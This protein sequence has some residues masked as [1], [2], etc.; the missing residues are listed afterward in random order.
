MNLKTGQYLNIV[1]KDK[2][3]CLNVIS[4][5]ENPDLKEKLID[6]GNLYDGKDLFMGEAATYIPSCLTN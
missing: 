5:E 2:M 1:T 4:I 6:L 3:I